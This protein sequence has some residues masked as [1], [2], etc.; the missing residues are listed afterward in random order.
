MPKTLFTVKKTKASAEIFSE[1]IISTGVIE[2][3][4]QND[5]LMEGKF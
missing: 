3:T 1:V 2:M 4:K 5:L